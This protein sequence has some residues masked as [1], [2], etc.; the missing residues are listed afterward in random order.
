MLFKK[1]RFKQIRKQ[2]RWS[3]SE[4]ARQSNISR[5]SLSMWENGKLIPSERKIRELARFLNIPV[6]EISDL[7]NEHPVSSG[8]LSQIAEACFSLAEFDDIQHQKKITSLFAGISNLDKKVKQ[9]SIIINA[10]ISSIHSIFY[11]KDTEQKYIIANKAFL[12][13]FSLDSNYN[14]L[15]KNDS[16]LFTK[17]EALANIEE[18]N[19]VLLSGK[20]IVDREGFIFGTRKKKWGLTSKIPIIDQ[21]KNIVGVAG[22]IIDITER[23]K[24]E[25]QRLALNN[26]VN[27]L[28]ECIWVAEITNLE[29]NRY[30]VVYINDAIEKMSGIKKEE[31]LKDPELWINYI[32]P[33]YKD[34]ISKQ[35]RLHNFPRHYQYKAIRQNTGEEYWRDDITYRNGNMF[36]GISRDVSA[37]KQKIQNRIAENNLKI[38]KALVKEGVDLEIISKTTGI[39]MNNCQYNEKEVNLL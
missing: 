39:T 7:Y 12:K 16:D 18:D 31:F 9:A 23:K 14:V 19:T 29:K 32:H 4:L 11:V 35:R 26:A 1:D 28:N 15:G 34:K 2:Q 20:P 13:N 27:H 22:I 37:S 17:K 6:N 25:E 33:D 38:A 36:F 24:S 8:G 30:K 21:K 3:L 5:M 10:L